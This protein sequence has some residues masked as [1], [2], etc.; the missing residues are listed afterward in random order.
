HWKMG[1]RCRCRAVAARAIPVQGQASDFRRL[2]LRIVGMTPAAA[3]AL[4]V[5]LDLHDQAL[6][7]HLCTRN[8]AEAQGE[9]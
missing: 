4:D 8:A 3:A 2:F 1:S 9:G 7:Q 5:L 6:D